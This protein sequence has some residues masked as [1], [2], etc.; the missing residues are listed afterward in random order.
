MIKKLLILLLASLTA[1][2][3]I[4]VGCGGGGTV[5]EETT[6]K[7]T[8]AES[9]ETTEEEEQEISELKEGIVTFK[10]D[11]DIK[12]SG[13]IFGTGNKWVIL[14]HMLQ[15]DQTAWFEFAEVLKQNGFIVLT[16]DFRGIGH[17]GGSMYKKGVQNMYLD[18]EAALRFIRQFNPEK[19]F[20]VGAGVGATVSLEVAAKEA[21]NG[22][23]SI[24]GLE[25]FQELTVKDEIGSVTVP[26]LFIASSK[27]KNATEN[28]NNLYNSSVDPKDIQ[29]IEGSSNGTNMLSENGDILKQ[30]ILD[31]LNKN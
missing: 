20:F 27:D 18:L 16:Y 15:T 9:V 10:T 22:V 3:L 29:I 28:A 4:L 8:E 1:I 7:E 25:E 30:M 21:V 17:S 23:I 6:A 2:S 26:K 13:N 19:I 31:F 11:D 14:S 24:S 12:I 5:A